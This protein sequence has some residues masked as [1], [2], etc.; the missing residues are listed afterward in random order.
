MVSTSSTPP[1]SAC[2][3]HLRT[4]E[5][6]DAQLLQQDRHGIVKALG[7]PRGQNH[8]RVRMPH[9]QIL[10]RLQKRR[11]FV[12]DRAAAD[13]QRPCTLRRKRLD[14]ELATIGGG[15]GNFTSNFRFP[16]TCTRPG[17]APIDCEPRAVFLPS[18]PEKDRRAS[19]SSAKPSENACTVATTGPRCAR[20]PPRCALRWHAPAVESSARIPFPPAP[21]TPAATP[22]DTAE[23][24]TQSPSGNKIR[25]LPQ[26]AGA[27]VPVPCQ[28]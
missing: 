12:F 15:A 11:F 20:S 16:V 24:Q 27:P 4:P 3:C 19:A 13:Q 21:S 18:A 17:S 23:S 6:R 2:P 9:A 22:A 8:H 28:S 14:A 26:N 25:S 5:R 1:A 7:M 10:K